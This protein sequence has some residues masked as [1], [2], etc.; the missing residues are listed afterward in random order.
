MVK[1]RKSKNQMEKQRDQSLQRNANFFIKKDKE[2]D[3]KDSMARQAALDKLG[4]PLAFGYEDHKKDY[5]YAQE[6]APFNQ[7]PIKIIDASVDPPALTSYPE[8]PSREYSSPPALNVAVLK[9]AHKAT[10]ATHETNFNA[11]ASRDNCRL[12]RAKAIF[13]MHVKKM[14]ARES[15][16]CVR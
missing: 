12:S 11:T 4:I 9:A 6:S 3:V 2:R 15:A 5:T 1:Q 10:K 7:P 16:E 8:Y 14:I 13:Q